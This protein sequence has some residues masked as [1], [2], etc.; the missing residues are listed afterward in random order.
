MPGASLSLGRGWG[1]TNVA[2]CV[3]RPRSAPIAQRTARSNALQ[4][5]CRQAYRSHT[6]PSATVGEAMKCGLNERQM[7]ALGMAR[8][9]AHLH[10]EPEPVRDTMQHLLCQGCSLLEAQ[11]EEHSCRLTEHL[12]VQEL[13]TAKAFYCGD[14]KVVEGTRVSTRM[15]AGT[16]AAPGQAPPDLPSLLLDGRICY[17]G[18][19]VRGNWLERSPHIS[20]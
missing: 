3:S 10:A 14:E 20:S 12:H 1:R 5:T 16:G 17:I 11:G 19:P 9:T 18:M 15:S 13:L 2:L 4:P 8:S 7:A 6:S